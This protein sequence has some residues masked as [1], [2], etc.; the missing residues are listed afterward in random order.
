MAIVFEYLYRDA[1]N[2]KNWGEACFK[3]EQGLSLDEIETRIQEGL[4][5]GMYFSAEKVGLPTLYFE[6]RSEQLDHE[7][8]EYDRVREGAVEESAGKPDIE[9]FVRLLQKSK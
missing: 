1:G 8:H 3:N 2:F 4:I 7:W 5:D 9:E 6:E